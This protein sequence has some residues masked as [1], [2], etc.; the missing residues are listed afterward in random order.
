MLAEADTVP[1]RLPYGLVTLQQPVAYQI[2]TCSEWLGFE[3]TITSA[4]LDVLFLAHA[5]R[6]SAAVGR[7]TARYMAYLLS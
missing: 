4:R 7:A 3:P 2:Q 6:L 1:I 5:A